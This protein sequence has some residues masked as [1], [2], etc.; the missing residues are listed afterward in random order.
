MKLSK[1]EDQSVNVSVLLRKGNK[2]IRELKGGSDLKE[3]RRLGK[4]GSASGMGRDRREFQ[5]VRKMKRNT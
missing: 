1:K 2:I 4:Q 3:K 5:R